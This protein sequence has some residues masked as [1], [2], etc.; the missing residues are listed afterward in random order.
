M[1]LDIKEPE[2]PWTES[3]FELCDVRDGARLTGLITSFAPQQIYH[4]AAQSYPTVSI[5]KPWETF[6][7]NVAGTVNLFEGLRAA[8]SKPIVVVACSSAEYGI[9][10]AKD[11]PVRESHALRPMHP[12]GVSKVAQDLLSAQYA[13]NYGTPAIRVRIFNTTGPGKLG[14]LCS[15]VA[16]RAVEIELGLRE[17]VLPIGSTITRRTLIDV[18]DLVHGLWLAAERCE[19]GEVYNLGGSDVYS[20]EQVIDVVGKLVGVPFA[21]HQDP[22]LVRVYDE[23]VIAGDISKFKRRCGWKAG[24]PLTRTL[25]DMVTWWRNRLGAQS[26]NV[27][28]TTR[29][30]DSASRLLH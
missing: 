4:L 21:T 5:E 28:E 30:A 3:N 22:S 14:D 23:P 13:L 29:A 6:E 7:T 15:D 16:R 19:H 25:E 11:L 17:P 24:I 26:A 20:V 27:P 8:R 2:S 9:V 12:Y 10:A 18:R 1:G